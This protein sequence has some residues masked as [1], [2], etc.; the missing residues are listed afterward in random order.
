[1]AHVSTLRTEKPNS[2]E[3][4]PEKIPIYNNNLA[5][6]LNIFENMGMLSVCLQQHL[7]LM[8]K[9]FEANCNED[10][11]YN[12]GLK[13]QF[14][15]TTLLDFYKFYLSSDKFR[16]FRNHAQQMPSLFES[17]YCNKS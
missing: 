17:I 4:Y 2:T 7:L 13:S 6:N 1:M 5:L 3:K 12:E 15:D 9:L 14:C 10:L 8:S 16:V 11:Q